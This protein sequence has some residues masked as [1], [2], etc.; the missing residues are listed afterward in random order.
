M[1]Y[2]FFHKTFDI[3]KKIT[4]VKKYTTKNTLQQGSV[5]PC[6]PSLLRAIIRGQGFRG[7][8]AGSIGR[9]I[10]SPKNSNLVSAKGGGVYHPALSMKFPAHDAK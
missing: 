9:E 7:M 4:F 1:F 8:S 6:P 10:A 2:P 3:T 5:L